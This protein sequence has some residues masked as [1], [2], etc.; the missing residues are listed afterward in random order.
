[1]KLY[2]FD[3]RYSATVQLST[4]SY[5][6]SCVNKHN[7]P[8]SYKPDVNT[9]MRAYQAHLAQ[10]VQRVNQVLRM[11]R[12]M[13]DAERKEA[14]VLFNASEQ[15]LRETRRAYGWCEESS[16]PAIPQLREVVTLEISHSGFGYVDEVEHKGL[17]HFQDRYVP[18]EKIAVD[19]N[20]YGGKLTEIYTE[21]FRLAES[22][23][24]PQEHLCC[25][26]LKMLA[27]PSVQVPFPVLMQVKQAPEN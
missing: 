10:D 21:L 2:K 3:V 4:G 14:G 15:E 11:L 7:E 5:K 22:L 19:M 18:P 12:V 9:A 27:P 8:R 24:T 20:I 13:P 23:L 16:P 6:M 26:A 25:W 1:M 17:R